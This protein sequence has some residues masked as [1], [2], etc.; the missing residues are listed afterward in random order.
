MQFPRI[1][2]A[3]TFTLMYY[4]KPQIRMGV[5]RFSKELMEVKHTFNDKEL[6][7]WDELVLK[8]HQSMEEEINQIINLNYPHVQSVVFENLREQL[9]DVRLKSL[10][11][12][13]IVSVA[14]ENNEEQ[15][16]HLI[17]YPKGFAVMVNKDYLPQYF[18]VVENAINNL[19]RIIN[20]Y[21]NLYDTDKL[22]K[23]YPLPDYVPATTKP[24]VEDKAKLE[25]DVTAE[26]LALLYRLMDDVGVMKYKQKKDMQ[27][28]LFDNIQTKKQSKNFKYFTNKFN[29]I[30]KA[31]KDYWKDKL[32]EMQKLLSTKLK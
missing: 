13:I 31:A 8:S 12:S 6:P 14:D 1:N 9:T 19:K 25:M 7:R 15:R 24:F 27:Q 21:L 20:K 29:E 30:D 3:I 4:E 32:A 2:A 11:K 26:Q 22:P 28:F 23:A 17:Q 16:L 10:N 18:E 5:G